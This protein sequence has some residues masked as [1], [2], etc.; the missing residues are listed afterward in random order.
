MCSRFGAPATHLQSRD[1]RPTPDEV[2]WILKERSGIGVGCR[3][4]SGE[5]SGG[6]SRALG[7]FTYTIWVICE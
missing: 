4:V 5:Y 6:F 7:T 2:P 1:P 3:P